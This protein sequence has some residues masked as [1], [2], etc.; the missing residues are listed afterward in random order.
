MTRPADWWV[1]DLEGDPTPGSGSAVRAM[2]RSWAG[3]ADDAEYA[4]SRIRG[5]M[6]DAAIGRWIGE[7]GE[8]FRAKTGDLPKQLGQCKA[9]YRLVSEALSW[10]AGRLESAQH[11]ADHALVLG[12]AA[13]H[14]LDAARARAAA[15]AAEVTAAGK[16]GV[17]SPAAGDPDPARVREATAR[18][19]A[20]QAASRSADGEVAA[21]QGRLDAARR[22]ALD[23]KGLREADGR[24]AAGRVHEA[25]DA[26]IPERSRWEKFKD[27]AGE[28][29][30]VVVK[31]AK[32]VVAVLG[33][34]ALIIG[35]PLAWVVFAA[36]LLVLADTIMKYVQGKAS[37]WDVAFAALSCIP[38]TKGL[39]TLAELRTAFEAGGL[40]GAGLHVVAS[41]KAAIVEMARGI[42]TMSG[43]L[44][45]IVKDGKGLDGL[46]TWTQG[47]LSLT[48]KDL[49]LVDDFSGNAIRFE[50]GISRTMQ[51]QVGDLPTSEL[52][53][54]EARLKSFD[55]LARKTATAMQGD[56]TAAEA[57]A[58]MKDSIR[59]TVMTPGEDFASASAHV[60]D[61]L[62]AQGF[63]NITF[64][65][66]FGGPEY[67]GINTTWHD[68]ATGH[69]FEVQFHTPES[70]DAKTATHGLYEEIRLPETPDVRVQELKHQQQQIFDAV[71]RPPGGSQVSLPPN[72]VIADLPDV[73]VPDPGVGDYVRKPFQAAG[74]AGVGVGALQPS[75]GR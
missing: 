11:D 67:Q 21:A 35:G 74:Y 49:A 23:A 12:R 18:L 42:K 6:G 19:H 5:L 45:T 9:S 24:T 58:D 57:L 59:Y 66:S 10:W 43:N 30:D 60:T 63:E 47:T 27:W 32:V 44:V 33:V 39:T 41:G 55:S 68:P 37:L 31:I 50:P 40:L 26:G 36:A 51:N 72:V 46:R 53:G 1:L 52:A 17:L 75:G 13:R 20:A 4:E 16:A 69:S 54:F 8:A 61:S 7:A 73:Y 71:P 62:A 38:G 28:A 64:K 34:V 22:M 15:A 48:G 70:F 14:D 25:S 56:M 29:W 3:I 65:N 2:A